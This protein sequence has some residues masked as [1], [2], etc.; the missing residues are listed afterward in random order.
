MSVKF[1]GMLRPLTFSGLMKS[2][3][4]TTENFLDSSIKSLQAKFSP[5]YHFSVWNQ[6]NHLMSFTTG[7]RHLTVFMDGKEFQIASL[8]SASWGSSIPLSWHMNGKKLKNGSWWG[9]PFS[10]RSFIFATFFW[11]HSLVPAGP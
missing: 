10:I 9:E 4:S 8:P 11:C 2:T 3:P 7:P 5:A 1:D 6:L